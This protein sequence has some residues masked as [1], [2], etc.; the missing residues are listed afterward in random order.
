MDESYAHGPQVVRRAVSCRHDGD[1]MS[2]RLKEADK[3]RPSRS[4]AGGGVHD[5]GDVHLE[6]LHGKGV[7]W[8]WL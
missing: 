6:R 2:N 3:V 1:D 7:S 5:D 4:D 8:Q